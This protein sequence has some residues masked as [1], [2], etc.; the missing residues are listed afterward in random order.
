[1]DL[2]MGSFADQY[3]PGFSDTEMA[4]YDHLLS[5]SDPDL[6]DWVS[7]QVDPP[8]NMS[9]PVLGKLLNHIYPLK[10]GKAG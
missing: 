2:L 8:A 6:Y 3:V 7:G 1:M 5:V 9:G 10:T 4:E